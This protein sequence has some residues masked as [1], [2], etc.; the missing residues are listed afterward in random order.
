MS[1]SVGGVGPRVSS[2]LP[3][4]RLGYTAGV[5]DLFHVGHLNLFAAARRLCDFLIVGVTT[6]ELA[7]ETKGERPVIPLV[8]RMAIVQSV[9]YVDHAVPQVSLDKADAW[10][11]LRFDVLFAGDNLRGTATWQ[12]QEEAMERLG[13]QVTY[14]PATYVRTG[15]LLERG[16]E[17]QLLAE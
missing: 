4:V 1:E 15:E 17:D 3:P 16:L 11:A 7:V 6:D 13:V 8:E 14:L 5:F 10:R 2:T 9:R 12:V